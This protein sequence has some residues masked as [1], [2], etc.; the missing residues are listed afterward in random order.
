MPAS[1]EH[2]G[3]GTPMGANLVFDAGGCTFRIGAPRAHAVFVCGTFNNWAVDESFRLRPGP[4]PGHWAGFIPSVGD[5]AEYKFWVDGESGAGWKRDPYARELTLEP[6]Y[7][8][9]NCVVRDPGAYPWQDAGFRPPAFSDLVIYQLHIGAFGRSDSGKGGRFLDVIDKVPYLAN[10]GVNAVELLPIVEFPQ[11]YSLGYN[12]LD[13]YSPE[14]AYAVPLD[15]IS[16]YVTRVNNL[17]AARGRGPVT[18]SHLST[19]IGQLKGMM[20]VCHAYNLAV[21]FDVVYNHASSGDFG[22]DQ[23]TSQSIYFLDRYTPGSNN[24]SLYF[25]DQGWAGGLVFA[26][27]TADQTA[28][29]RQFLIDNA[30]FWLAEAHADGLRYD[31]VTVIDSHGGWDF[32]KDLTDRVRAEKPDAPQIAEYWRDDKSWVVRP[33][34]TGGAGFDMTWADGLRNSVRGVISQATSGRDGFVNLD[35]VRDQ[36]YP[37]LG[38][39]AAWR[40]VNHLENHDLEWWG[41]PDHQK[42]PR[43]AALSDPSNARSWYARSRSRVATGLLLTS[44]GVPMLFMGQ[45][46]LEDKYWSDNPGD[47]AHFLWWD[48]LSLDRAMSDFL[49]FTREL[50]ALRNRHPALRGGQVNVFHVHN[51]NRVI[52]FQRWL[53]GIGQDVVVAVSLNE[54]T[55]YGYRIGFPGS[56]WWA[57]VFNSDVYDNWVNPIVAGNGRR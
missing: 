20:E 50:I 43:I 7:P 22:G 23:T 46:F 36:L 3:A 44:T 10:L 11:D 57:E 47:S 26:F 12:G 33:R 32:C 2:I 13:Y 41:P 55:Y 53:E 56:G 28:G 9:S 4:T 37:P 52:A 38:A 30:A 35:P 54:S 8:F 31:E 1:Q 5:G 48:G 25:T 40:M 39:D 45:E 49:R 6:A 19:Q 21:I 18:A 29:V 42:Q 15:E 14:M 27:Y 17:L 16:A 34:S 24:N 51:E